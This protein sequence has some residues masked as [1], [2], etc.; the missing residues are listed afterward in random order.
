MYDVLI[1]GAG[2]VGTAIARR[3]SRYQLSVCLVEKSNDVAMGSTKANSAIVH[4]GYAEAN[5]KLKGRLCYKGRVQYE[6]LD[7]ELHFGFRKTGS[8]VITTDEND[9][10]KL[11]AMLENG[12][13]N[14]LTDLKILNHDEILA[15]EPNI[16]P[17][18]LYAL[19]CE[20]AGVCSPYEMAIAMAENAVHNGVELFLF[21]E[22]VG[23][24]K[25]EDHFVVHMTNR[26]FKA[27]YVINAAGLYSD[28]V[29]QMVN[30]KTFDIRP[31]SGEYILFAPG[32][33]KALN[34]VVFQMPS[35]MGK[36]NPGH[37][38]LP[39]QPALR[40]GRHRRGRRRGQKHPCGTT[41]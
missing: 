12:K 39:R 3:L 32:T 21:S 13:K 10:P 30:E 15:L 9:L 40:A 20:G 33:G 1:I 25:E 24:D 8:L 41:L 14:G 18:V 2:I 31:R 27:R 29:D 17:D 5:A 23:I 26:D 19:Y 37:Q 36:G 34:T 38:H 16:N 7:K 28:K 11:E 6:Q 22:V 4:G 35:K